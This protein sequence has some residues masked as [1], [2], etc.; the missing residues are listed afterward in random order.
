M[1]TQAFSACRLRQGSVSAILAAWTKT[2]L[3]CTP[4]HLY[5]P[6][7]GKTTYQCTMVNMWATTLSILQGLLTLCQR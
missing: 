4:C 2:F 6:P 7:S 3:C 1:Q 5:V